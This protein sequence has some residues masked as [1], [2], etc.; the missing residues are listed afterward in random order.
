[1]YV[2][3]CLWWQGYLGEPPAACD[4]GVTL[5]PE[6]L[7]PQTSENCFFLNVTILFLF[8][9]LW[10]TVLDNCWVTKKIQVEFEEL[11]QTKHMVDCRRG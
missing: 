1:M 10:D 6:T 2:G 7:A 3:V 4:H 8:P 11:L 9:E 5:S